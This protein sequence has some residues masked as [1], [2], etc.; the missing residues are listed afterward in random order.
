LSVK[1]LLQKAQRAKTPKIDYWQFATSPVQMRFSAESCSHHPPAALPD[2]ALGEQFWRQRAQ[3]LARVRVGD[4]GGERRR[5]RPVVAS[6][7][8]RRLTISCT[9]SF[10]ALPWPDGLLDLQRGVLVHR[11]TR[12][13]RSRDRGAARL[14]EQ[15]R[16]AG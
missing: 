1:W 3:T 5:R 16:I 13:H 2:F 6:S 11:H 15:Q 10:A 7:L 4:G 9:C 8:S 12:Q 14:P